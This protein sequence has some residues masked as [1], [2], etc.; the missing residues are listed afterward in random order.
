M[1]RAAARQSRWGTFASP[2]RQLRCRVAPLSG[3]ERNRQG[4][5]ADALRPVRHRARPGLPGAGRLRAV[6]DG[7]GVEI[8]CFPNLYAA[9]AGNRMLARRHRT[10]APASR[11]ARSPSRL[12]SA[13]R[14]PA[15]IT[16][17]S[18]SH[19]AAIASSRS[20]PSVDGPSRVTTR[21]G[22]VIHDL[23]L[24]VALT[25]RRRR[26]GGRGRP[27]RATRQPD[28]RQSW[29]RQN[30][31]SRSASPTRRQHR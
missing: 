2:A 16:V 17:R 30:T 21:L 18:K 9:L 8:G 15:R 7:R 24:A 28:P 25:R 12:A 27:Q 5:G 19:S 6:R 23:L 29:Q 4:G 13:V 31:R 14:I 26:P 1:R 22:P 10:A 11:S 3:G 20:P